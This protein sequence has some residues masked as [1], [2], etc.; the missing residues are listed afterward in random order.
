MSWPGSS[1]TITHAYTGL[2]G[3]ASSGSVSFTLSGPLRNG[4]V[5][6]PGGQPLVVTLTNGALSVSLPA[7][8]D[9][10]SIPSGTSYSVTERIVG[11]SETEY[12]ITVPSASNGLTI[13]LASLLP[14]DGGAGS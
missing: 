6:L 9:S 13:D 14:S 10:G 3:S 8:D 7:N 4:G 11:A 2:D 1:V 5:T 12:P